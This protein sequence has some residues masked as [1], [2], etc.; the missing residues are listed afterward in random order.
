MKTSGWCLVLGFGLAL[1]SLSACTAKIV[2][3]SANG[4]DVVGVGS[5]PSQ[6][7]AGGPGVNVDGTH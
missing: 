2:G 5:S 1:Q 7:G 4:T 3:D 6:S